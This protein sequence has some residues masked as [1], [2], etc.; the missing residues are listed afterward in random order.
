MQWEEFANACPEIAGRAMS[1]FTDADHLVLV[2]TIRRDGSPR[3]SPNE[4]EIAAGRLM[5]GMMWRSRKAMDILRD[6]R[7]VLHS[8]PK[9][10][11][12]AGGDVKLYGTAV[13]ENDPDIRKTYGDALEARIAW[14]PEE[15]NYHLFSLEIAEA[16]F[17]VFGEERLVLT[18]SPANG[19]QQGVAPQ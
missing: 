4:V 6:P 5:L 13:E 3:I 14:R 10:R 18:W 17:I 2:G 9:D 11:E 1:R 12:G 19:L 8:V 7:V 15:P 16:A